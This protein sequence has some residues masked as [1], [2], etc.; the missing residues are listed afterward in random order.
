MFRPTDQRTR[1]FVNYVEKAFEA[2]GLRHNVLLLSPRLSEAAVMRRQII[3]GVL[4]VIKLD[5]IVQAKNKYSISVFDRSA[6]AANVRFDG[7]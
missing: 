2:R 3:E 5:H 6:G 7:K 4:A 1:G